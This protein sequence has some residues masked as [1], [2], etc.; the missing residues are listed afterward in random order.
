MLYTI[1]FLYTAISKLMDY[2]IFKEQLSASPILGPIA[3][4]IA[5][6]LPWVEIIISILLV[7]PRW[8]LKGLYA[9][10]LLMLGFTIYIGAILSFSDKLPCSCGG[11]IAKMSWKQHLIFNLLFVGLAALAINLARKQQRL[12]K[13]QW[14][15]NAGNELKINP[16][17][18]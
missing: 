5:I 11:I 9:A 18:I 12:E 10:M 8:R 4:P 7:I 1:L 17:S 6:G 13:E 3:N 16:E 15:S 14:A 2:D